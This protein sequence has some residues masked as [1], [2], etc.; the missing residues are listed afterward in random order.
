[1][2]DGWWVVSSNHHTRDNDHKP[3]RMMVREQ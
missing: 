1:M 3:C 2:V